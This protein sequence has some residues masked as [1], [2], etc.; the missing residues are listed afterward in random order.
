M[1]AAT[2]TKLDPEREAKREAS[3][4]HNERHSK[5]KRQAARAI[6]VCR[7]QFGSSGHDADPRMVCASYDD[8]LEYGRMYYG[9]E[10]VVLLDQWGNVIEDAEGRRYFANPPQHM[11][12]GKH[13]KASSDGRFRYVEYHHRTYDVSTVRVATFRDDLDIASC[14]SCKRNGEGKYLTGPKGDSERFRIE[15]SGSRGSFGGVRWSCIDAKTGEKN[16]YHSRRRDA[17]AH[18]NGVLRAESCAQQIAAGFVE[19]ERYM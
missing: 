4:R 10:D 6:I 14:G 13:A 1:S 16:D 18:A 19:P 15:R 2:Q 7:H 11:A 3:R 5:F 9:T 12:D 17:I 8:V